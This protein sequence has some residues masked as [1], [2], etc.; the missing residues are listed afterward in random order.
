MS[1][2]LNDMLNLKIL[3]QICGGTGVEMNIAYL[4]QKLKKHRKTIKSHANALFEHKLINKPVYPFVW[5]YSEYPLL[6]VSEADLPITDEIN[7]YLKEDPHIFGAFFVRHEEYN[8]LLIEMHK[9][10]YSYGEWRK[11]IVLDRKIPSRESRYPSDS[12]LYSNKQ[13]IKY[14]P[15]SSISIL[16]EQIEKKGSLY[17]AG[18]NL[19]DL[20]FQILKQL[21][22]GKGIRTNEN[23]LAQILD[24]N[25][26][27]IERRIRALIKEKVIAHPVCRY[28]H[29]F[30]PPNYI[31]VY[32]L[33]EIKKSW[34]KV[35]SAIK[36]DPHVPIAL[37]ANVRRYNLLLFNVFPDVET[38]F[39]WE[40]MYEKRFPDSIGAVRKIIVSPEM[41]ASMNQQKVSLHIIKMRKELLRGKELVDVVKGTS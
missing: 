27:T 15:F 19:C 13:F 25:R 34:D 36:L 9:D 33:M 26:M 16:E 14:K 4:A 23:M 41:T 21:M 17:L 38:M 24:V 37:E 40:R 5:L 39:R 3:E 35:I 18:L 30:V 8:T 1:K 28:P 29:F 31:L 7:R 20:D 32:C 2:L 11:R 22:L 6:V 10:I 12:F